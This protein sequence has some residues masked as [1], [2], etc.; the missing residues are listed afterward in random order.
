[1]KLIDFIISTLDMAPSRKGKG[2]ARAE[3]EGESSQKNVRGANA[4][5]APPPVP[6]LRPVIWLGGF[7]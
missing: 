6:S 7:R 2:K 3:D 1:M 5:K 4:Y